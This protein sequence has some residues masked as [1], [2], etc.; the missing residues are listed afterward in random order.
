MADL[1]AG[2][3]TIYGA[4]IN[5]NSNSPDGQ[6]INLMAQVLIDLLEL[7]QAVYNSFSV[8]SAYGTQL[9]NRV[10]LNG[11]QRQA[12]T[13]TVAQVNITVSGAVTLYGLDQPTHTT[14]TVAD[15]TGNKFQLAVTHVFSGAGNATL[16]FQ[17][18]VIGQ[19]QTTPNTIQTAIT[20]LLPVTVI[21]NPSTASDVIGV[22][23][24]NDA[25]LRVR[26]GQSFALAAT[27]PTDS[28]ES[29]LQNVPGITDAFVVENNTGSTVNGIPAYSVW[30][31]VTGGT[32]AT[33]GAAIYAKKSPGCGM[34]GAS[35]YV[36]TRPNGT[37]FTAQWDASIAQPLYI[38]FSI[39]WIGPQVMANTDIENALAA[40]LS[41]KLGKSPSIGDVIKA[42]A[43]IIPTGI[44]TLS[45][46]QGVSSDNSTW[47]SV[48]SPTD[49]QHYYTVAAGNITIV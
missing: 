44:I 12:G 16:A 5:V 6:F 17:S 31:I 45:S 32:A 14:F 38:K 40:A 25:Q 37:T 33:I 10:A 30:P 47:H 11:L 21:N 9:D 46:S 20:T 43:V 1:T 26:H 27:G 42:L 7:V 49:Y 15:S 34:K 24:E 48:V 8:A 22:N 18:A 36:V 13:Y 4:S 39:T 28:M 3:Q 2:M 41:Y 29:A 35:T 19:V 23:E